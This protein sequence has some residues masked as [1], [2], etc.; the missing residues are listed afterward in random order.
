MISYG[1]DNVILGLD[2]AAGSSLDQYFAKEIESLSIAGQSTDPVPKKHRQK[3]SIKKKETAVVDAEKSSDELPIE[4]RLKLFFLYFS[5]IFYH[6]YR[7][8]F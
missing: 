2:V 7:H 4:S 8:K 3:R 5:M 1:R 6:E